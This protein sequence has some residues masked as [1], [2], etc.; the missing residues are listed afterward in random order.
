MRAPADDQLALSLGPLFVVT[1]S[2][3]FS[4]GLTGRTDRVYESPPQSRDDALALAALLLDAGDPLG[5]EGP[6]HRAL[7]GGRRTVTLRAAL[8]GAVW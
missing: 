6:W 7:A 8:P 4:P 2:D 1:V 5:G 3:R